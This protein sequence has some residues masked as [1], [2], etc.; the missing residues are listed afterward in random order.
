MLVLNFLAV[1]RSGLPSLSCLT[2]SWPLF[3]SP[4]PEN[5]PPCRHS[6]PFASNDTLPLHC[7]IATSHWQWQLRLGTAV[8]LLHPCLQ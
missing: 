1:L 3:C 6:P 8:P 4:S 7:Y 2:T 5:E